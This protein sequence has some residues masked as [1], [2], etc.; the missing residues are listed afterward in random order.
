[1]TIKRED[2]VRIIEGRTPRRDDICTIARYV[3]ENVQER[4]SVKLED[5]EWTS[6][7]GYLGAVEFTPGGVCWLHVDHGGTPVDKETA[8][9]IGSLM[10]AYA[11]MGE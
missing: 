2:V 11:E 10:L 9:K 6:V 1:M 3:L 8:G 4:K 5:F 7:Q